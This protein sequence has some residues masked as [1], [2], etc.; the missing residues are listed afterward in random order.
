VRAEGAVLTFNIPQGSNPGA[1]I[2]Y[3]RDVGG[4]DGAVA[5][6]VVWVVVVVTTAVGGKHGF[7]LA[8]WR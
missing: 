2:V 7:Q 1:G 3:T 6:K 5:T 4:G 8:L